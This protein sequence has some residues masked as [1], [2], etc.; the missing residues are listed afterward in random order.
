MPTQ[1]SIRSIAAFYLPLALAWL[2]MSIESPISVSIISRTPNAQVLTAAFLIMMAVSLWIESPVID[3]LSTATTL[4]KSRAAVDKIRNFAVQMII[5]VT[6]IHAL[7]SLTPLYDLLLIRLLHVP[8]EV[9]EAARVPLAIMTPWS[10]CIG[11]RRWRQGIMIRN[12]IT[13][14]ITLG[15]VL[16]M[17][18]IGGV[19]AALLAFTKWD[20]LTI[21]AIALVTSVFVEALFIHFAAKPSIYDMPEHQAGDEQLSVGRLWKFHAPLSISTLVM[22][23]STPLVGAALARVAEPVLQ[24]AAWQV[25]TALSFT[26]RI[27]TFGLTE[28]VI[29]VGTTPESVRAV[30]RFCLGLGG[31]LG[32]SMVVIWA[33]GADYWF[34]TQVLHAPP[35]TSAIA[36]TGFIAAAMFPVLGGMLGY[37]KGRL[38]SKHLTMAR[39][40]GIVANVITLLIALEIG[41]R[42]G[43]EGVVVAATAIGLS[44]IA[45]LTAYI[46]YW[47]FKQRAPVMA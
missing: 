37:L 44:Q 33:I 22:L 16:R 15:T 26:F 17:F 30:R 11:W 14:P 12:G 5:W 47:R 10:G 7:V 38:T 2:L 9:A 23:T 45:E 42:S 18:T 32:V 29:T 35:G 19:G 6:A 1:T 34:F 43:A 36:R 20:G 39:L 24:M 4:G 13:K 28:L 3:L 46:T 31:L 25:A 27:A 41:V 8:V 21:A 40:Y